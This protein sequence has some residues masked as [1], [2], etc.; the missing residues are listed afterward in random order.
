MVVSIPVVERIPIN[1]A[2]LS[3]PRSPEFYVA[4]VVPAYL[5]I[6]PPYLGFVLGPV[7]HLSIGA[8]IES[9]RDHVIEGAGTWSCAVVSDE[10]P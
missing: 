1:A 5:Q 9:S 7:E 3:L 6:Q 8:W 10:S 4:W 2:T